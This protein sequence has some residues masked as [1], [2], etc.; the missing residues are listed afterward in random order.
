[1]VNEI[2]SIIQQA[3]LL[4]RGKV[5]NI[6]TL[7]DDKLLFE[8]SDRVSAFDVVLPTPI[9]RKGEI[10]CKFAQYWFETLDSPNHMVAVVGT[11]KMVVKKL[12]MI[13]VECIVRGYLYGSLFERVKKGI[14]KINGEQ[15]LAAK[16]PKPIFDPTTKSETHDLPI[17][18]KDAI[19]AGL[20]TTNTFRHLSNKSI[21]LYLQMSEIA[22]KVGFII[23]DIK[24]EFGTDEKGNI[25]LADSIGPDEFRLWP[26]DRYALGKTQEAF[27]KQ[28]VRD[29]LINVGYKDQL[30]KA[31]K[32]DL[33]PPRP[34]KLPSDL[35]A[36]VSRRYIESYERIT[37]RKL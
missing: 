2:A 22:S 20:V 21:D 10:L 35:V 32:K 6:Y 30:D 29:W 16:L 13:M 25:L 33:P 4:R 27:D 23:A 8:F 36:Q 15:I 34:P 14:V 5:K 28:L 12:K 18:E 3:K 26:K 1:M 7:P 17:T 24:F 19:S 31:T 37:G 9:P 11:N